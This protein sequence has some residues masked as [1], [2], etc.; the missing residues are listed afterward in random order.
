MSRFATFEA[1]VVVKAPLSFLR[2]EFLNLDGIYI[3]GIGISLFLG[4]VVI[5]VSVILEGEEQV[6]SSLG[7]FIGP[8]PDMF[9]VECL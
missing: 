5:V 2:G 4:M 3:H 8:F 7:D 1:K 6:V 9:K